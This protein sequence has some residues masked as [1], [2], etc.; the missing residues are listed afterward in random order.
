MEKW[1]RNK[2]GLSEGK[3]VLEQVWVP[4]RHPLKSRDLDTWSGVEEKWGEGVNMGI[5][6]TGE[7]LNR[8]GWYHLERIC[9]PKERKE[10]N[11]D[12]VLGHSSFRHEGR[13]ANKGVGEGT[14]TE[15]NG[16]TETKG[17][18]IK[19]EVVNS[20]ECCWDQIRYTE[21]NWSVNLATWWSVTGEC[22]TWSNRLD[23][24]VNKR[25]FIR[26]SD[27]KQLFQEVFFEDKQRNGAGTAEK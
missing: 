13:E 2:F 12:Q 20:A 14:S 21:R 25:W 16:K 15:V 3:S 19:K 17:R 6:S 11:E 8:A 27:Y 26:D 9:K 4:F 1:E 24:R 18:S 23:W 5:I 7:C 22:L 10:R